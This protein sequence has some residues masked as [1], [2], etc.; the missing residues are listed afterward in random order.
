M[1]KKK[2]RICTKSTKKPVGA[3]LKFI[4]IQ[5]QKIC[6]LGL[7]CHQHAEEPPS[8]GKKLDWVLSH[9]PRHLP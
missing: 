1:E 8:K 7:T 9:D 2:K 6:H 3:R 5:A 4:W